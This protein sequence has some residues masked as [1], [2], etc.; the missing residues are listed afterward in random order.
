MQTL[1]QS[2]LDAEFV[3]NPYPFYD[4]VRAA[5]PFVHWSHYKMP[6]TARAVVVG[7]ALRDRRL[8]REIPAEHA[9]PTPPHLEA[10]YALERHSMLELEAPHHTR[11]RRLVVRAFT[12]GRIAALAPDITALC[13][14]LIDDM[15]DGAV[16]AKPQP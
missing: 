6:V 4:R 3:Q 12:S 13:H 2:P 10:F 7:A 1:T 15:P 14:R 16:S 11:L 9:R 5:G 8:G